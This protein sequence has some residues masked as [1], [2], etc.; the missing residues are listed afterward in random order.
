VVG[1]WRLTREV[2]QAQVALG[3][4]LQ[5][6]LRLAGKGNV[7]AVTLPALKAPPGLKAYEPETRDRTE[8]KGNAIYGERVVEYT[9]LPQ[10][11]GT[12]EL[13][14]L[15]LEYFDPATRT[16]ETSR[17]EPVTISVT[18]A[19]G[20]AV[21]AG[22]EGP[23]AADPSSKNQLVGG[24]LK[25]LRHG[26]TFAAPAR[27]LYSRGWF[28]PLVL[29]PVGLALLLG[30]GAMAR[31][32]LRRQSP[33]ALQRQQARAAQRRLQAARRL[34]PGAPAAEFYAEVER[35]LV[36]FLEARLSAPLQGLTRPEL[37]LRL[38]AARVPEA[39]RARILEVL[40]RCDLGR[41]AREAG[42]APARARA[43]EDAA[44]AME[45]WS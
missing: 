32:A 34:A 40:E 17:V 39:E 19:T 42:E 18:P 3:D 13:P 30:A 6:K 23:A 43:L 12:F 21:A 11:T 24:G 35:A 38:E 4:P 22:P 45:G 14:A 7:Q 41:Y 2:S 36:G 33:Q 27:P 31:G 26:A 5:V 10:Q 16:W 20:G 29:A 15:A 8:V 9:L 37:A 44:A 28:L 25:A 1:Q